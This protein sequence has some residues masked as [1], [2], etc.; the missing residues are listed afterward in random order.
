MSPVG[1]VPLKLKPADGEDGLDLGLLAEDGLRLLG[2]L[3]RVRERHAL[4]PLHEMMK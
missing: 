3:L 1:A 4:G 2:D